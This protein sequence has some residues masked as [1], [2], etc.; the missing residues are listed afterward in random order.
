MD[1][2]ARGVAA[3]DFDGTMAPGDSLIPFLWRTA[4]AVRFAYAVLRH[5]PRIALATGLKLGDRD[6]AKE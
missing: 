2:P 3:F 5:G 6:A 1:T 4:G